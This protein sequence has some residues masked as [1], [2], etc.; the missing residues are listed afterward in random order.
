M[1]NWIVESGDR[2]HIE[3]SP[4]IVSPLLKEVDDWFGTPAWGKDQ[5]F[6]CAVYTFLCL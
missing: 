6:N 3:E 5:W 2:G 1:S 4:E